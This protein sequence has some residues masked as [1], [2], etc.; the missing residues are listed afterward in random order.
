MQQATGNMQQATRECG[1]RQITASA[2]SESFAD[3]S[4]AFAFC[5]RVTGVCAV[6]RR[7][8]VCCGSKGW[9]CAAVRG[10][11]VGV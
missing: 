3:R 10:G 4:G 8:R 1:A 7:I 9:W 11:E 5:R 2:S 6:Q